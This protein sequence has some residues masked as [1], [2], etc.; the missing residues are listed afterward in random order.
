[1]TTLIFPIIFIL[2]GV[3]LAYCLMRSLGFK[4]V[5]DGSKN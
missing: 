5:K 2:G 4:I 3:A 1:M